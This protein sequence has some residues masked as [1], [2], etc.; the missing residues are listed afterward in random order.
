MLTAHRNLKNCE[1]LL[2]LV[3]SAGRSARATPVC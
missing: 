1:G 3:N 2:L